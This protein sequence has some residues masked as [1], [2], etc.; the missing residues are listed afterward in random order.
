MHGIN[1]VHDRDANSDGS[2]ITNRGDSAEY[3][4]NVIDVAIVDVKNS[5]KRK[6]LC[7]RLNS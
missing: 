1:R 7:N 3:G 6:L 4:H 2:Y 5:I